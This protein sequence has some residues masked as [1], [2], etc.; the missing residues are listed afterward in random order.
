RLRRAV[1]A[2]PECFTK[3]PLLYL[4]CRLNGKDVLAL[5]DTGAQTSI[6]SMEAVKKCDMVDAVD[7][8]FRVMANGVGGTRSSLGRIL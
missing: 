7:D 1:A 6:I 2:F 5:V 4:R 3:I 8:R